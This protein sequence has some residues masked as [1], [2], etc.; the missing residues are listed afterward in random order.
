MALTL[1]EVLA[2]PTMAAGDPLLH[3][4]TEAMAEVAVRWVHSSEV[5]NIAPLLRG[6]ELLLTGGEA[7][8]TASAAERRHYIESLA[9]RGIAALAVETGGSLAVMP[10]EAIEA[11]RECALAL[12]E[13]RRVVPFVAVAEAINST[14]VSESVAR[15]QRSDAI[16]HALALEFANGGS[17]AELVAI[18]ARELPAE[19]ALVDG[20]GAVM[21]AAGG[22]ADGDSLPTARATHPAPLEFDVPV[23][24]VVG[25][26]LR[27]AVDDG[28]DSDLAAVV[29]G[30][31]I[32]VLSLALLKYQ[33]PTLREVGGA[34]LI[35]AVLTGESGTRLVQLAGAAGLDPDAPLCVVVGQQL[36]AG[37]RPGAV[38]KLLASRAARV[39]L[40]ADQ[41]EVVAVVALDP[42]A[43][44]ASRAA[45]MADLS[46]GPAE[47]ALAFAVGPAAYSVVQAPRSLREARMSLSVLP[48][49]LERGM[50]VDAE[51]LAVE[52]L[53]ARVAEPELGRE[54]V[55]ELIGELIDHDA[56][57]G[58]K[59]V[60]TLGMWLRCGCNTAE[61][62]RELHL[63]R[64][65]LHNRL[66]RI[67]TLTGGDP[68]GTGRLAG[69]AVAVRIAAQLEFNAGR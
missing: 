18:L 19:V 4:E 46:A 44:R 68:R 22:E 39:V 55:T 60:E 6:G 51:A 33:A 37:G 20:S 47:L 7:L 35:R 25:A 21:A 54:F 15:L 61:T 30:R 45:V 13:L 32:D 38:E 28:T 34:E 40:H 57:R 42:T 9:E 3:A 43:V 67:F 65:S 10:P 56:A 2:H 36:G 41:R 69:L 1:R 12:I 53:A 31:G 62:A 16:S 52:R 50:V 5:L 64:Q 48:A 59:L 49:T 58:S 27:L 8:A 29:G 26:V 23:R 66:A 14:L 11:A 24:G 63:E 17:L